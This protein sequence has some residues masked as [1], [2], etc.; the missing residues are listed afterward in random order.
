V[1]YQS[2]TEDDS[3]WQPH[4]SASIGYLEEHGFIAQLGMLN[5]NL[6]KEWDLDGTV[7]AGSICLLPEKVS[8]GRDIV[9]FKPFSQ[10]PPTEKDLALVVDGSLLAETVRRDL[11][12]I[13]KRAVNNRYEL[14]SVTIFDV[15]SGEGLPEGKK[16][17]A[18]NM[19]FRSYDRT[20]TDKE[21]GEV[22][23][24][25]QKEIQASTPYEV[26]S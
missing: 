4:H 6:V 14:E 15:Y 2:I 18:F 7:L 10:F 26:R 21:V 23:N 8:V 25:V 17:L 19:K 11:Q 22:F 1:G 13:T 16:S 3:I 5:V 12:K 20:L 9:Q 24:M